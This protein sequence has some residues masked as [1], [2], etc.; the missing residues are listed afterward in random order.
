MAGPLSDAEMD[1]LSTATP[2]TGVLSDAEMDRMA[3]APQSPDLYTGTA[4]AAAQGLTFGLA[5]EAEAGLRT[6]F[7][8]LGDYEKTR[9]DI[10]G[11][12]KAFGKKHPIISTVAEVAG[13]LPTAMVPGMGGAN[14]ARATAQGGLRGIA[15]NSANVGMRTGAAHG[16]GSA[17]TKAGDSTLG[18]LS[19][20]G[21]NALVMGGI[22]GAT[23][24][25]AGPAIH[26]GVQ[27]AGRAIQG[28]REIVQE[29][30]NPGMNAARY[31]RRAWDRDG[32][33]DPNQV[34]QSL[35]PGYGRG[36]NAVQPAQIESILT[37]YGREIGNGADDLAARRV[38][39]AEMIRTNPGMNPRTAD[40]QVRQI[41]QRWDAQN[42]QIPAQL[43]ELPALRSPTARGDESHH[44]MKM[45]MQRGNDRSSGFRDALE[46]RQANLND[47]MSGIVTRALGGRD[48]DEMLISARA[49]MQARN[50]AAYAAAEQADEAARMAQGMTPPMGTPALQGGGQLPAHTPGV[51]PIDITDVIMSS[52]IRHRDRAGPV[53]A[54]MREAM[55]L[56]MEPNTQHGVRTLRQF[57]DQKIELDQ[58][59]EASMKPGGPGGVSVA[60]PLTRELVQFKE[61]L[62]NRAR[63]QNRLFAEANDSAAE[64]FNAIRLTQMAKDLT[65]TS[66]GKQRRA[67]REFRDAPP[68]VQDMMRVMVAQN[69]S[70]KLSAQGTRHNAGKMFDTPAARSTLRAVLGE[71]QA[72]DLLAW[73]RRA[74]IATKSHQA[75]GG[76][77]TAILQSRWKEAD[78][79]ERIRQLLSYANPMKAV[80]NV[81]EFTASK[82][83]AK[84]DAALLDLLGA[85]TERP[86][87]MI[88]NL[89]RLAQTQPLPSMP[90][91]FTATAPYAA[92]L[93]ATATP[94][95]IE[96]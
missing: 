35:L 2:N 78:W 96:D 18:T 43:H 36:A 30:S 61:Q 42:N 13:A 80:E 84:R 60:T 32:G 22:G 87:Q 85:S 72:D 62:M 7:G 29:G 67:L 8:W 37:T 17:E 63:S 74:S 82:I 6:G 56:F 15:L 33:G 70:D 91:P 94:A 10:R 66:G 31:A 25:V 46:A 12:N 64:Q 76:S 26:Y 3:G 53:A 57:I 50:R 92:P 19:D 47:D 40:N 39:V 9:D 88:A 41:V 14:L 20:R 58:L 55:D 27:G 93:G 4:R 11:G 45:A 44:A 59:I 95:M 51:Q 89:R 86:D 73:A 21:K 83:N 79:G 81:A 49:A 52:A 24:L 90:A 34:L 68:D 69:I 75:M 65:L 71:E 77:Q 23:G 16:F 48:A 1:Q 5:D 28:V 38:A 54:G